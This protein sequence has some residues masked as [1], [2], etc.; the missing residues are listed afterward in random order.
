MATSALKHLLTI[1][2]VGYGYGLR[3]SPSLV[4]TLAL[5]PVNLF[6]LFRLALSFYSHNLLLEYLRY[7]YPS[8]SFTA[9]QA[10]AQSH[11]FPPILSQLAACLTLTHI[12]S[13]TL[14]THSHTHA[15]SF[16]TSSILAVLPERTSPSRLPLLLQSYTNSCC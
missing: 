4:Y 1:M 3:A 5:L 2:G 11:L 7:C 6:L 16:C 13:L 14:L 9:Q 12:S 8:A 15:L 10:F